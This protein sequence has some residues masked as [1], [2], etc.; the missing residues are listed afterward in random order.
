MEFCQNVFLLADEGGEFAAM[1]LAVGIPA[2]LFIVCLVYYWKSTKRKRLIE[3]TPTSKVKGVFIGLNEVI[4][5]V[6]LRYPLQSYL[7]ESPCCW[8]KYSIEEHYTR[9]RTVTDSKGNTRTET[10]SGWETVDSGTDRASFNLVD[11]TGKV[12]VLPNQAEMEGEKVFSQRCSISDPLY[13]GKGPTM[14]VSGSNHRRKFTESAIVENDDVYLLGSAR[15]SDVAA[16]VEIA[17]DEDDDVFMISTKSESELVSRYTWR[18]WL[19]AFGIVVCGALLPMVIW[20]L[21]NQD[22]ANAASETWGWM[23][24]SGLGSVALTMLMYVILVFNGLVSTQQRLLRAWSLIDIQLKRR[25][26]LIANLVNVC[27]S[28]MQHEQETLELVSKA[29]AGGGNASEMPSA[30]EV[31]AGEQ[32]TQVQQVVIQRLFALKEAYP[33]LKADQ[34]MTDL[35]DAITDTEDRLAIAR[36]FYNAAT[37]N[38]NTR[39]KRVPEIWFASMFGYKRA[40]FYAVDSAQTK[41]VDVAVLLGE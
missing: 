34:S 17:F 40:A 22:L 36:T 33:E 11:D 14:S 1:A 7:N 12:H 24:L 19:T 30:S 38:Y 6:E 3:D 23:I 35:Q 9:T 41:N 37:A 4:G 29:R 8:Y 21:V 16:K 20:G 27:Q 13:Y 2:V 31:Q 28:Y 10:Y 39:I 26:D 32:T 18:I 5:A 15:M 25:Y